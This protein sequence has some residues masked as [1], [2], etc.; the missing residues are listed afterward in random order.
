[1]QPECKVRALNLEFARKP[2]PR[3]NVGAGK[4]FKSWVVRLANSFYCT[5]G[6]LGKGVPSE[7]GVQV[8]RRGVQVGP[9]GRKSHLPN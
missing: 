4:V 6:K 8:R 2:A 1:M 9:G 5:L 3:T 7:C